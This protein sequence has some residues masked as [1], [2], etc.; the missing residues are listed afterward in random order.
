LLDGATAT[1]GAKGKDAAPP[2]PQDA[3]SGASADH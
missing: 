1:Q 3:A 2:L